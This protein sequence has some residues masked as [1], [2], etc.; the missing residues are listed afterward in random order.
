[1]FSL[2]Q[3]DLAAKAVA[4]D[5]PVLRGPAKPMD[6]EAAINTAWTYFQHQPQYEFLTVIQDDVTVANTVF[7]RLMTCF[8]AL[9]GTAVV[10]PM[11]NGVDV[12][13]KTSELDEKSVCWQNSNH[14]RNRDYYK[15]RVPRDTHFRLPCS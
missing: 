10:G 14:R 3:A 13:E 12:G 2:T 5:V 4:F 1:M 6:L 11:I 15:G 9:N 8:G 7:D